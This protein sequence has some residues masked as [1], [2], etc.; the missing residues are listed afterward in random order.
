MLQYYRNQNDHCENENE[1]IHEHNN[2]VIQ[3]EDTVQNY[4]TQNNNEDRQNSL[5]QVHV[6]ITKVT[7][8][9]RSM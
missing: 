6:T 2:D 1:I 5:F 3:C 8:K 9:I 4:V 7:I